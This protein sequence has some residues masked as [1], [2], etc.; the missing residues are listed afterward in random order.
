MPHR[1][2]VRLVWAVMNGKLSGYG[3]TGDNGIRPSEVGN[4]PGVVAGGKAIPDRA[5]HTGGH[6]PGVKDV[7]YTYRDTAELACL[8]TTAQ[9]LV[10]LS[11]LAHRHMQSSRS[12]CRS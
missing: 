11:R 6:I 2:Q 12:E 1:Q 9:L 4:R 8:L 3:L 10:N 5:A 7:F